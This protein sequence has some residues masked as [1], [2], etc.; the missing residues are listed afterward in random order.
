MA[1]QYKVE[2]VEE[3]KQKFS[4]SDI[5][6][7]VD[8]RGLN[9]EA[10]TD[11]RSKLREKEVVYKVY[12]NTLAK[13][14]LKESVGEDVVKT[15]EGPTAFAFSKDPVSVSKVLTLFSKKNESL[16][17][18]GGFYQGEFLDLSEIKQLAVLPSKDE[19]LAKLVYL[20][21]APVSGIVNVL[22][23]PARKLVYALNAV[24]EQKTD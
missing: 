10:V 24:K 6:I 11:L 18:K 17:I 14:A 19:L 4:D 15:L 16:E 13:I 20:L 5:V 7:F 8:Y 1:N 12:K 21:N 3:I 9:V 2:Q 22:S 23:G